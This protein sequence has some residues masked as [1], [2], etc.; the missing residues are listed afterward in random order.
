MGVA[1][2]AVTGAPGV[3]RCSSVS[4]QMTYRL[5]EL[6][7]DA[8]SLGRE[9]FVATYGS[10]LGAAASMY[11]LYPIARGFDAGLSFRQFNR[12][13]S[14]PYF[15]VQIAFGLMVGYLGS[16]RFGTRFYF[17]VWMVPL[18]ILIWHFFAFEPG[19]FQ[20]AWRIRLDHFMGSSCR[21]YWGDHQSRPCFD[22]LVYT[23]PLYAS[24]AYTLGAFVRARTGPRET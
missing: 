4:P 14:V 9:W 18:S 17:L 23:A 21:P 13:L 19:A 22:Q 15:P 5:R 11:L 7:G 3:S 6:I 10:T 1:A 16:R 24:I 20:N 8:V 2:D 12:A